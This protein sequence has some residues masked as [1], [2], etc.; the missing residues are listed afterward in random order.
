M[1]VDVLQLLR[2]AL[3]RGVPPD[4][5]PQKPRNTERVEYA[6]WRFL[7]AFRTDRRLSL[8]HA[9]LLRQVARCAPGLFVGAL[10]EAI[11]RFRV[12]VGLRELEAG[13][14]EAEPFVPGWLHRD[15]ISEKD[16]IDAAPTVRR[17]EEAIPAEPYLS[18]LG[19]SHWQSPAQK[20][21]AW[22]AMAARLRSTTLIALPTGAGKSLCFQMLPFVDA[23]L[24]LVVV[25]TVALAIDQWRSAC[26]VLEQLPD[27]A[28]RFF[29][30]GEEG[31]EPLAAVRERRTRLVF[32]SPEACTSGR[33]RRALEDAV[34]SG[35]LGNLV[36]D[37]AHLVETWGMFFRVDFQM[38]SV[39]RRRWLARP[40]CRLRTFL[41][42]AT[43]TETCRN[44]LRDL[45]WTE[46]EGYGEFISQRLRPEMT[47]HVARFS[48]ETLRSAAALECALRLPRPAILYTTEVA[49]AVSL[50]KTLGYEGF[51]RIECFHGGTL[52]RERREIL[53]KWDEDEIDLVV[54][55]SA[56]GLGVDKPDVRSVVHACRP[57]SVH[58]YYQEVGRGGRDGRSSIC[59]L[60]ATPQD[61]DIA[62][63]LMPKL[64]LPQTIQR[65]WE[66]LWER[67]TPIDPER[68]IYELRMDAKPAD[69]LGARTYD[70]HVR[71]N[72]RLVL[73]LLRAGQVALL[74]FRVE[75]DPS[76]GVD[77]D[78]G[79]VELVQVVLRF[80]PRSG[81]VGEFVR[82]QRGE[83]LRI[84]REG[85]VQM[86]QILRGDRCIGRILRDVYGR[87]STHPVCGGCPAC[88]RN[89]RATVPCPPLPLPEP[90][91]AAPTF[92]VIT[93]A[94]DAMRSMDRHEWTR[95]FRALIRK[96]IRRFMC[97]ET[98]HQALLELCNDADPDRIYMYR[99][100]A[101][102]DTE[103]PF[104]VSPEETVVALHVDRV[105][106]RA[107]AFRICRSII[108][109]LGRRVRS[110]LD[111]HGR[112][113]LES[114]G[115]SCV[116]YG[117]W[118]IV[119]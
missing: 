11:T 82:E 94:P 28:P 85:N 78:V 65:R 45:F 57:E 21:A 104:L 8:D 95:M 18:G 83:E 96:G 119:H 4:W 63:S 102:G 59:M 24:T 61:D 98:D 33:L 5:L 16:G 38:L 6:A 111:I 22:T 40:D 32:A 7:H 87:S 112:Y 84:L 103:T 108:H 1:T 66:A 70:E 42:S 52:A 49:D 2:D 19:F 36:V 26:K 79:G 77:G 9:V 12:K 114:D 64:L 27:I 89:R 50:T 101:L 80:P 3:T 15:N 86:D 46:G 10:P 54:A 92:T 60:L 14:L 37:E 53:K 43:F 20:E 13:R 41:L 23:G 116:E 106:D 74:D 30:A 39:M 73:Q 100:D 29:A 31:D 44:V 90:A 58:R 110:Y 47:Y 17:P 68:H 55:T 69:L 118:D 34:S 93:N 62:S 97:A 91:A 67:A 51:N 76:E 117:S 75:S 56:F 109:V 72:K 105:L 107:L 25:P 113:P 35:W 48:D 99:L 88:R 71:W 81:S 115:A